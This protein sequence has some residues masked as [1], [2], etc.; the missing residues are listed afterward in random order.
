MFSQQSLEEVTTPPT[1]QGAIRVLT[2]LAERLENEKSLRQAPAIEEDLFEKGSTSRMHDARSLSNRC[3][4]NNASGL[5]R[6]D[7]R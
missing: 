4:H 6:V 1:V 5:H 2:W 3:R 7:Y